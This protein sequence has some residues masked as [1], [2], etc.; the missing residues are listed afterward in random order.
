MYTRKFSLRTKR[1]ETSILGHKIVTGRV[2]G[3]LA[4][5]KLDNG[6]FLGPLVLFNFINSETIA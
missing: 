4:G 5:A 2:A 6:N 1:E 3:I